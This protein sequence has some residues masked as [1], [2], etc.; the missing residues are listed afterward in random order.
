[1][2][3]DSVEIATCSPDEEKAR[4]LSLR[5]VHGKYLIRLLDKNSDPIAQSLGPH[6][7]LVRLSV[8]PSVDMG[9]IIRMAKKWIVVPEC[10]VTVSVNDESETTIG[11]DSVKDAL[12]DI[13]VANGLLLPDGSQATYRK[14]RIE[15]RE[16]DGVHLAYAL[17]FLPYFNVWEFIRPRTQT[18]GSTGYMCRGCKSRVY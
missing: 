9:D 6:G 8:R 5:S 4:Y 1:M 14:V 11:H 17:E 16:N 2:I 13:L 18:G 10:K 3:A 12:K 15:E 7:T